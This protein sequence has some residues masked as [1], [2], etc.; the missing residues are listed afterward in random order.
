MNTSFRES[1]FNSLQNVRP[2][3][4]GKAISLILYAIA[5]SWRIPHWKI[6]QS[7]LDF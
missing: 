3:R 1:A 4:S 7:Y 5:S 2:G 6:I